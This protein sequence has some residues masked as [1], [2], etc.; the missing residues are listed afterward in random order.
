MAFITLETDKLQKNFNYLNKI[1]RSNDIQ[2]SVVSKLL[3]GNRDYLKVLLDMGITSFCDSRISNL[4]MIKQLDTD[5]ETIYIKPPAKRSI[6]NVVKYANIS[7]NT[8]INTIR[9]LSEE[10]I[11][12][13]TI[14]KIIIMIELGELREGVMGDH[15]MSF[16]KQVFNLKNIEVVGIGTN[17][18]CL[19]GVLPNHDKLIQLCLYE[20]LIEARFNKQIQFVSGG[21]SVTIPLIFQNL[22]PKGINHFRVGETLFL[23]TDVYNNTPYK[24]M[25]S[26]VFK[27]YSEIIELSE[28]P[29]VPMGE[30]GVNVEGH[31]VEFDDNQIGQTSFRAILD[32]GLLDVDEQHITPVDEQISFVGASSDMLVI[33]LKENKQNYKVGDLIEFKMDYMGVLRIINSKYIDKRIKN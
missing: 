26:D 15:F 19:Y 6:A 17:L 2:W 16:Y 3:C 23:G 5:V 32:L 30:M 12:Q 22:L 11:K 10:A 29:A 28:K 1:F 9:L 21:S 4:K 14:H 25:H 27:L 7:L 31:E 24:K 33:D 20:Q 8:E 13:N 18:S